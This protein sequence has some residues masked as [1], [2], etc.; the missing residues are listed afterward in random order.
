MRRLFPV[1]TIALAVG[2]LNAEGLREE[3]HQSYPLSPNGRV[4]LRNVNGAV[5]ITGWDR[6]EVQVSAVKKAETQQALDETH[7]EINASGDMIDIRTRYPEG[8]RR[9]APSVD[10]TISVPRTAVLEKINTVNG[11]VR[12]EGVAGPEAANNAAA[13]GAFIPLM[14][15][16]IPPNVVM[17]LPIPAALIVAFAVTGVV[18][19]VAEETSLKRL[20]NNGALI[21]AIASIAL[22]L[23][24]ENI[25]RFIFGNEMRG[26][27]LPIARDMRFGDLRIGPQQLQSVGIA[28]AERQKVG[29]GKRNDRFHRISE[30]DA[31]FSGGIF[32]FDDNHLA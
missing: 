23:V 18:G 3:F 29:V 1:L 32:K 27:D 11:S 12:I 5:C 8:E 10:Y 21:V 7:I 9:N 2:V 31:L 15:L 4:I 19:V 24:L 30:G 22:N 16:G 20:R 13:G 25:V 26:Y 17:A 28:E 14:T 6:A